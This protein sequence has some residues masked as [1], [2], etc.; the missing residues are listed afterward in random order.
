MWFWIS[1]FIV[2]MLGLVGLSYW[3]QRSSRRYEEKRL[4]D[5][6]SE[7]MKL[8]LRNE[9]TENSLKKAEFERFL[10]EAGDARLR[11]PHR[12]DSPDA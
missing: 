11:P 5:V 10:K 1:V 4:R 12:N 7:E 9:R 8:V 3:L 2:S 6:L